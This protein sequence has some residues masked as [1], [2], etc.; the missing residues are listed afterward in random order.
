MGERSSPTRPKGPNG[1]VKPAD[2]GHEA[3][4]M[5][6]VWNTTTQHAGGNGTHRRGPATRPEG[7]THTLEEWTLQRVED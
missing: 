1:N 5:T 4:V 6:E 7:T 3:R 2:R